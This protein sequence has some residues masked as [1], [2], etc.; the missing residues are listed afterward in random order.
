MADAKAWEDQLI[1]EM[2]AHDG[3]VMSGPL[4][5]HPLLVLTS[6]GAKS[7][8]DRR[9]I[10][11]YHRNGSDYVVAGSAGGSKSDPSWIHNLEHDPS[12][13]IEVDNRQLAVMASI[14]VG[15]ERDRLWEEHVK[16]LPWFADYPEQ[17]GRVIPI[18][19]LTPSAN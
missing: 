17:S 16:A 19:R 1:N 11:T 8:E 9:A 13:M 14:V 3:K 10:L 12:V 6:T 2:R 4:A 15:D 18:V 7:G 5:G